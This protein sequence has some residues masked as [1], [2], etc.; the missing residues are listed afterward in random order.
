MSMIWVFAVLPPAEEPLPK[1][2]LRDQVWFSVPLGVHALTGRLNKYLDKFVVVALLG[3]GAT[4]AYGAA[5]YEV[6]FVTALPFAVGA[7]FI[8]RYV[9]AHADG[10]LERV[11]DLW[12]RGVRKVSLA[13]LPV[14]ALLIA[15]APD[16]IPLVFGPEYRLAIVPFQIFGLITMQRVAQYGSVLQAFGQTTAILRITLVMVLVN[17]VCNVPMTLWLGLPGTALATLISAYVGWYLYVRTIAADLEL[18]VWEAFPLG[19]YFRVFL[20]AALPAVA[21]YAAAQT[22]M[23]SLTPGLRLAVLIPAYLVGYFAIAGGTGIIRARDWASLR[24]LISLQ[25]LR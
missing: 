20:A 22:V 18:P 15:I 12:H 5:T 4:A 25:Y 23:A 10:D 3:E 2:N 17:L 13:V 19:H 1:G 7:V 8:S 9:A 16:L 24:R 11:K 6:P 14:M 21:V